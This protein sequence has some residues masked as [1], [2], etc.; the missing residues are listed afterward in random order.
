[1]DPK[2]VITD[3]TPMAYAMHYKNHAARRKGAPTERVPV[4]RGAAASLLNYLASSKRY[5]KKG[6]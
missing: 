4:Y 5:P 1:M 6:K 3:I 2:T